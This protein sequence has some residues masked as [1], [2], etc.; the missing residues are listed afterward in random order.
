MNTLLIERA[1]RIVGGF[2]ATADQ[3]WLGD[4]QEDNLNDGVDVTT[5]V[6]H[7]GDGNPVGGITLKLAGLQEFQ[8]TNQEVAKLC[9]AIGIVKLNEVEELYFRP[10]KC[11]VRDG[12]VVSWYYPDVATLPEVTTSLLG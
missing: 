5:E 1:D 10:F 8:P 9:R 7:F 12:K 3:Y 2:D 4:W 11:K 6:E